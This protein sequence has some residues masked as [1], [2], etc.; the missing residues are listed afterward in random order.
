MTRKC[1]GGDG[2]DDG[3]DGDDATTDT[4]LHEKQTTITIIHIPDIQL[5]SILTLYLQLLSMPS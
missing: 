2:D 3:D 5:P 1:G 4:K